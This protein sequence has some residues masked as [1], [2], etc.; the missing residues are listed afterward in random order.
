M[1][2]SKG[3][4]KMIKNACYSCFVLSLARSI[5]GQKREEIA[6]IFTLGERI[7]GSWSQ[8]FNVNSQRDTR[9]YHERVRCYPRSRAIGSDRPGQFANS[10]RSTHVR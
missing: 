3:K 9:R 10:T 5:E 2:E 8:G 1:T 4:K 7:S 6:M